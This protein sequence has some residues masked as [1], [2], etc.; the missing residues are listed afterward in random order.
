MTAITIGN[1]HGSKLVF[2]DVA[3]Q[4]RI[5]AWNEEGDD[6][7]PYMVPEA[8]RAHL[9]IWLKTQPKATFGK[10]KVNA[11]GRVVHTD[12]CSHLNEWTVWPGC[13]FC[14]EAQKKLDSLDLELAK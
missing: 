13:S 6:F 9:A 5:C 3:G 7:V 4:L 2:D 12:Q 14:E 10:A 11:A 8:A 1:E